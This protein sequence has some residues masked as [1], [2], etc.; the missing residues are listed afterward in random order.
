MRKRKTEI[1]YVT[2]EIVRGGERHGVA[3]PLNRLQLRMF[4]EIE[5]GRRAM[6]WDNLEALKSDLHKLDATGRPDTSRAQ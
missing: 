4:E 6:S 5:D 3:T 2:G 1:D